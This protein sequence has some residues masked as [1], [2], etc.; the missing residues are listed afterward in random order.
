MLFW[1]NTNGCCCPSQAPLFRVLVLYQVEATPDPVPHCDMEWTRPE[2]LP[3]WSWG[4]YQG[5]YGKLTAATADSSQSCLRGSQLVHILTSGVQAP[6]C[7]PVSLSDSRT[8]QGTHLPHVGPR[9]WGAVF[10]PYPSLSRAAVTCVFS[11]FLWVP[12]QRHTSWLNSFSSLVTWL[13]VYLL[14]A[15]FQW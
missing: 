11:P 15:N 2:L 10:V 12:S 5:D 7:P 4:S 14:V 9:N 1:T 6:S 13:Y 3:C 8:S